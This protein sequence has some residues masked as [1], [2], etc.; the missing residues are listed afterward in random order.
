MAAKPDLKD[1]STSHSMLDGMKAG[2]SGQWDRFALLF[3][4][5]IYQW[6][7]RAGVEH[8][9]AADVTQE[10][11]RAVAKNLGD[12]RRSREEDSFHGWLWGITRFKILD[13]FR[14]AAKRPI[15]TGGSSALVEWNRL[16]ENVPEV[17]ES[18]QAKHDIRTIYRQA[19]ELLNTEFEPS[20]WQAFIKVAVDGRLPKDVADELDMTIGAIYNAKYKILRRLR[21]EFQEFF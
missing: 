19:V 5:L 7:R 13:H 11:F 9:D 3:T 14:A 12:F 21:S 2:D 6:C 8:Q 20:T 15:A 16:A 4:P 1:S 10:V 18:K 17:L